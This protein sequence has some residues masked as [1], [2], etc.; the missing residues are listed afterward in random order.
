MGRLNHMSNVIV[1]TRDRYG[2]RVTVDKQGDPVLHYKLHPYD[3]RHLMKGLLEAIRVHLAAG[4]VEV[5]SPHNRQ[6]VYRPQDSSSL[7]VFLN[8]VQAR[9]LHPN[10]YSLFSAHQMSSC[11]IGGDSAIGAVDP[12]G[13]NYEVRNLFVMDGSVLPTASG[14][15]PMVTIMGVA[16]Y[17]A[18]QLKARV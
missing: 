14:V 6:L 8:E 17:L 2:G 16:H 4:A 18:Q 1:L 10:A 3:A 5:S 12:N 11:R 9:G 13:E 15:N 7:D